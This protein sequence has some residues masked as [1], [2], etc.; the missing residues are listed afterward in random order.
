MSEPFEFSTSAKD[1]AAA[2]KMLRQGGTVAFPTETVYGLGA[3]ATNPD[4]VAAIYAAKGRPSFNPLIA[5][6]ASP[7][8]ARQLVQ[9]DARTRAL[10]DA[11]WP[12][13]LTLVLPLLPH[14]GIAHAVT[15]GL[16][17]LAVR[18]P[19]H[20]V[21]LELLLA[22]DRPV[23]AP[24]ANPSGRVS[25]TSAQHVRDGLSGR[26][27]GLIVGPPCAVGVESTILALQPAPQILRPGGV[28][29]EQIADVLQTQ[30]LPPMA[31]ITNITVPGQLSSHY[32]P[33][34]PVR[35]NAVTAQGDEL[36]I[37][38]GDI[39]GERTLSKTGNLAEAAEALF[40]MLL[41]CETQGR[42]L[43]FAPIPDTGIGAAINDRLQRAAAPRD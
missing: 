24:S 36:L 7:E 15:A 38:F 42:P 32:A 18:M 13:D 17:T 26:I 2:A 23:A 4:A 33:N 22:T 12:G 5:H 11:F 3:D 20:P 25:P 9:I 28:T 16:P 21:A 39:A 8:M 34:V 37:G 19:N 40:A 6:V 41:D 30:V 14:A 35:L 31:Q 10:M 29:L 1:I 43:A 27:N